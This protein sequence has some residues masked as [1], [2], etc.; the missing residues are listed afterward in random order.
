[1]PTGERDDLL[2]AM[3][4]DDP[5]AFE[6][7]R[8]AGTIGTPEMGLPTRDNDWTRLQRML[9]EEY[10]GNRAN[11]ELQSIA[12]LL[13]GGGAASFSS[14]FAERSNEV[15]GLARARRENARLQR[16]PYLSGGYQR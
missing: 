14:P 5:S 6:E 1:M 15:R 12:P 16:N 10:G 9:M 2:L 4:H 13:M 7:A 8:L 11:P 3:A